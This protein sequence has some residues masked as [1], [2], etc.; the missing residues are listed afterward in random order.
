MN[1]NDEEEVN[2]V[3]VNTHTSLYVGESQDP[4]VMY[5]NFKP[6]NMRFGASVKREAYGE[7]PEYVSVPVYY[8]YTDESGKSIEATLCIIS[9][10]VYISRGVEEGFDQK[11]KLRLH[12]THHKVCI[13]FNLKDPLH[14]IYMKA[15]IGMYK[16]MVRH[17]T[18]K[19]IISSADIGGKLSRFMLGFKE[20]SIEFME[21]PNQSWPGASF[22]VSYKKEG[23]TYNLASAPKIYAILKR[24]GGK[25]LFIEKKYIRDKD[26]NYETDKSGHK[27][28]ERIEIANEYIMV[29]SLEGF[30]SISYPSINVTSMTSKM[31]MELDGMVVKKTGP[32]SSTVKKGLM[33]ADGE[34]DNGTLKERWNDLLPE[35]RRYKVDTMKKE[36]EEREK[37]EKSEKASQS[38]EPA[39]Q[40]SP[41]AGAAAG[42]FRNAF[43]QHQYQPPPPIQHQQ[44]GMYNPT[45]SGGN[46]PYYGATT[47]PSSYQNQGQNQNQSQNQTHNQTHNSGD[48]MLVNNGGTF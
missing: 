27:V 35:A 23:S 20:E 41:Q 16:E 26:G 39:Q 32:K 9:P 45:M 13:V 42:V 2:E 17:L 29:S 6:E 19:E 14:I 37:K 1:S 18:R 4:S 8:V 22:T 12:V 15:H 44:Y 40:V 43:D 31:K 34:E 47:H 5:S 24:F 28:Y 11:D 10:S 46:Q 48:I 33:E 3:N 25:T 38:P 21:N 7:I 36:A 30:C